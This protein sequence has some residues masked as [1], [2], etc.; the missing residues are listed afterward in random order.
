[1]TIDLSPNMP[2]YEEARREFRLDVPELYN[3]G[4]DVVD[5]WA[6]DHTKLAL[7]SVHPSGD[8]A[9]KH[10]FHDLK[11]LSNKFANL[12]L[13]LGIEKGERAFIMAPRIPN[14]TWQSWA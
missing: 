11:V 1:M 7:V 14:G 12:L 9:D 3:F 2:D 8:S 5:N 6:D 4:F 10:T 13:N